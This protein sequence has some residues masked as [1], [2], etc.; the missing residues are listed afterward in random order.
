M[1]H[2]V[3]GV[4]Q[5]AAGVAHAVGGVAQTAAGVAHTVEGK[6]TEPLFAICVEREAKRL[7]LIRTNLKALDEAAVRIVHA[8]IEQFLET[9]TPHDWIAP[10]AAVFIGGGLKDEA[11][12]WQAYAALPVGGRLA[13]TAVTFS[14]M[15]V[16]EKVYHALSQQGCA[17]DLIRWHAERPRPLATSHAWQG[18]MPTMLFT[19]QKPSQPC[20]P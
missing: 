19:V 2:A 8:A 14:A 7:A 11:L 3:G 9:E 5:T 18:S 16:L 1:A 20:Q 17:V 13:A 15:Q 4:A 12:L 10:P 6:N